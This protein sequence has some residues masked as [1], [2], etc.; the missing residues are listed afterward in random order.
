MPQIIDVGTISIVDLVID[1]TVGAVLSFALAF[2]YMRTARTL[3]N[4]G[5]LAFILP[6]L[7]LTTLLVITVVKSSLA[8]SL[9]LVGAL[10]IVRFRTP[11]KEPEELAYIF[12]SIGIGVGLGAGQREATVVAV[13]MILGLMLL[14]Q[15]LGRRW[16]RRNTFMRVEIDDVPD[17][18]GAFEGIVDEISKNVATADLRRMDLTGNTLDIMLYISAR[19]DRDIVAVLDGLRQLHPNAN[20]TFVEQSNNFEA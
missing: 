14:P 11:I 8:L 18:Q 10:S 20:I 7:A 6:L 9:G 19:R 16:A 17:A 2:Y 15:F 13:L 12:L 3:S 1:L 5:Q 4:H